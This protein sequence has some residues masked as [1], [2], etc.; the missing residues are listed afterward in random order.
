MTL[1]AL[2]RKRESVSPA[3][4]NPAKAAND[5]QG[6]GEPLAGLAALALANPTE[7]KTENDATSWCW[8]LAYS[9]TKHLIVYF[10]PEATRAEVLER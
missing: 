7:A 8:W 1:A 2:I 4:A 3:N 10:H 9:E 5:G 6:E